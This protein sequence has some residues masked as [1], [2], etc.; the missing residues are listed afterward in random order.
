M[1][2]SL[3]LTKEDYGVAWHRLPDMPLRGF[4]HELSAPE[5]QLTALANCEHS[6]GRQLAVICVLSS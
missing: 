5:G 6:A 1:A 2:I 4:C 3:G